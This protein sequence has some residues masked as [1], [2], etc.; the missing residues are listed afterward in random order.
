M[1]FPPPPPVIPEL[2]S[3]TD[4]SRQV[5]SQDDT[6]KKVATHDVKANHVN[7]RHRSV[8][9]PRFPLAALPKRLLDGSD[10]D[11]DLAAVIAVW[12][13]LHLAKSGPPTSI[14]PAGCAF[15]PTYHRLDVILG[16][17]WRWARPTSTCAPQ[18][19]SAGSA[20]PPRSRVPRPP[21][22]SSEGRVSRTSRFLPLSPLSTTS[23]TPFPR[24]RGTGRT[25]PG[26]CPGM[27]N[28][29]LLAS[30][31]CRSCTQ[32]GWTLS[33]VAVIGACLSGFLLQIDIVRRHHHMR[34][35]F[36]CLRPQCDANVCAS[37]RC[38]P[39]HTV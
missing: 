16:Q 24:L 17:V 9:L 22:A 20:T 34:P 38:K 18:P 5:T 12:L 8:T 33:S 19:T 35:D 36:T 37:L 21:T 25:P 23:H 13:R 15:S 1:Q 27:I 26:P 14:S 29:G 30:C 28:R 11:H 6:A 32:P 7:K 2:A 3:S 31:F 39:S 10:T 4:T